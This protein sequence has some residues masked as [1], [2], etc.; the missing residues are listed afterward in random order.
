M[1]SIRLRHLLPGLLSLALLGAAPII[2]ADSP[3]GGWK[4]AIVLP[5]SQLEVSVLLSETDGSWSGSIDIPAQGAS[6]LPLIGVAVQEGT[7][8]FTI[9]GV[10]GEPTFS[11]KLAEGVIAGDFTQGGQRFDFK[12]E[13]GVVKTIK[14]EPAAVEEEVGEALLLD[15]KR[16]TLNGRLTLPETKL[17]VPVVLMIAGSGPTDRNGNNPALPGK[18]NM[19]QMLASDLAARSIASVRFD[20]R[21]V[22]GSAAAGIPEVDL[23]FSDFVDDASRWVRL[24]QG[25]DR[26]SRV[27]VLG[28][29]E[30]SLIGMLATMESEADAY[31]SVA[32]PGRPAYEVIEVQLSVQPE[33][34]QT[35]SS[36]ILTELR[37]GRTVPD[38]DPT[39]AALYRPAIQPYLIS[40]FKYDPA[41]VIAQLKVP[42]MIVQ[43]TTDIQ[44][45][46]SEGELLH[47]ARP[48]ASYEVV[49]RM[50]HVLKTAAADRAANLATYS[51]P[52]LPL[53]EGLVEALAT[54]IGNTDAAR[55]QD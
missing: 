37:A 2:A 12:L 50:N 34:I 27:I 55:A 41:Q 46:V 9:G 1:T 22:A 47:A 11:G 48:E 44:V 26:F 16:G 7:V 53:T 3:A 23:R 19:L 29:S 54:F 13:P 25:D 6:G 45:P 33:A 14:K 42:T 51:D 15:T 38:A 18:N 24:L 4:G 49:E 30:G 20:K 52:A 32:G 21:G 35:E 17:P 43:G 28:H 39:L 36:R 31:I 40:W 10:P 8:R 5:G